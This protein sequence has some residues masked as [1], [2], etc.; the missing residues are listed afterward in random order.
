VARFAPKAARRA[1]CGPSA[2]AVLL[3]WCFLL[4]ATLPAAA[5][6]KIDRYDPGTLPE[7]RLW[8][9]LLDETR[10]LPVEVIKGFSVYVNGEMID[11][12]ADFE[13]AAEF[14]APMLVGV[15]A[16]ARFESSWS[17]ELRAMQEILAKLPGGS[18]AFGIATHDGLARIPEDEGGQF[19]VTDRPETL[20]ASFQDT[21]TGGTPPLFYRGVKAALQSFPVLKSLEP[22]TDDGPQPPARGPKQNPIPDDRVLLV[23]GNG[24]MERVGEGK[25]A[26]DQLFELVRMARRRGVRVMTIGWAVDDDGESLWTLR[27]LAR[28]T[29][30]TF[31]Q[32]ADVDNIFSAAQETVTELLGRYVVTAEADA[33]R[34]GDPVSFSVTA[35][36]TLGEN[37]ES[38]DFEANV[39]H[40]M[41]WLSRAGDWVSDKWERAPFWIRALIVVV[42]LVIVAIIA[43]VIVLRRLRAA[44]NAAAAAA[45]ERD[46]ALARRRPCPVCGNLMMPDW[47][48]CLFCATPKPPPARFRLTG[49]A[50]AWAGQALRFD[51]DLVTFGSAQHVDV[52]IPE[53]RVAAEHC[54]LRDRGTEFILSDFNTELGTFVNGERIAQVRLSEG[55]VIR[56]G[57]T[58]LVFGI[59]VE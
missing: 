53:R 25:S 12:D 20:A 11:D 33:L 29:G 22:E 58:E 50:G 48:A 27:V 4:L 1:R 26:P 52:S 57:D 54:G 13:T 36:T 6:V 5:R 21:E 55:D 15:V 7:F 2:S 14:G 16:D 23:M 30:G 46:E 18:E 31:R 35:V 56:V 19:P 8:V 59:E 49:R 38:R 39:E 9:T 44:R 42:F 28:K 43:L 10:P 17:V 40:R 41:G 24:E 45:A 3:A 37:E 32:A 47:Q 51:K 34:P